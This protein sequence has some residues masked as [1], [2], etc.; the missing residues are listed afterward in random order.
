MSIR[1][2]ASWPHGRRRISPSTAGQTDH[3]RRAR[4][5]LGSALG[6]APCREAGRFLTTVLI[7]DI[8]GDRRWREVLADHYIACRTQVE[9]G[10]GELVNTTGDGVVAIF[11]SPTHAVRAAM[12]IQASASAAGI[13]VRAGLHTG[14]RERLD[15]GLTGA[16]VHIAARVCALGAADDVMTTGTVRDLVIGSMPGLRSSWRSRL[17]GVPGSWPVFSASDPQ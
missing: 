16:A 14:E 7:T 9:R 12:A 13:A 15:E 4:R 11:D 10:G 5:A 2:R 8:V 3:G 1:Q 6:Q 17:K